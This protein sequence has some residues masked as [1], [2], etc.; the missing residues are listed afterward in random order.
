M[1]LGCTRR[2][3]IPKEILLRYGTL[4]EPWVNGDHYHISEENMEEMAEALMETGFE[5][6]F[7]EDLPFH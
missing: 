4:Q 7:A 6:E 3:A 5:V 1:S 2:S